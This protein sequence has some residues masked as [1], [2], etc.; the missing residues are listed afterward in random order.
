M[1][2]TEVRPMW[3]WRAISDLLR[4]DRN[5]SRTCRGCD[6]KVLNMYAPTI[7]DL[8]FD[9]DFGAILASGVDAYVHRVWS[10]RSYPVFRYAHRSGKDA[11]AFHQLLDRL[12]INLNATGSISFDPS[13]HS[14]W[15]NLWRKALGFSERIRITKRRTLFFGREDTRSWLE[16]RPTFRLSKIPDDKGSGVFGFRY[17]MVMAF[18]AFGSANVAAAIYSRWGIR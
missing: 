6:L 15:P 4:P 10:S 17:L 11:R 5:S 9:S 7:Y 1:R 3:S 14:L 16:I 2:R 13:S 18:I 8:A 12:E